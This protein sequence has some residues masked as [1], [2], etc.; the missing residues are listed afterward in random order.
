MW[1]YGVMTLLNSKWKEKHF[2]A[3]IYES[4]RDLIFGVALSLYSSL[5]HIVLFYK[6]VI[7]YVLWLLDYIVTLI[8]IIIIIIPCF[9]F[10]IL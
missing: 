4:S 8:I 10:Y 6:C 2:T 5:I 1:H 7:L 9:F 3:E